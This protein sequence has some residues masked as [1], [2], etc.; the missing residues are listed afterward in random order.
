MEPVA[1]LLPG[2]ICL[3]TCTLPGSLALALTATKAPPG[4]SGEAAALPPPLLWG[5]GLKRSPFLVSPK[6]CHRKYFLPFNI[7]VPGTE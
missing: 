2:L 3:V 6:W 4:T 5:E 7:H 1:S